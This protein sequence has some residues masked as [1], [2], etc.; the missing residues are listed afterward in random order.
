MEAESNASFDE[1]FEQFVLRGV[2]LSRAR[3]L[4][5]VMVQLERTKQL[6]ES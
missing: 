5:D 6:L 3:I 4:S 2:D 1:R